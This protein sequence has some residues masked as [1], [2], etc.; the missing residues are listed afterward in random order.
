LEKCPP[1]H[2]SAIRLQLAKAAPAGIPI[3]EPRNAGNPQRNADNPLLR[4]PSAANR[5]YAGTAPEQFHK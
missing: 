3:P 1:S 2:P 4:L 5:N